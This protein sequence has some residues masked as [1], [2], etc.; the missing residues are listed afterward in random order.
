MNGSCSGRRISWS[1]CADVQPDL[2]LRHSWPKDLPS[3]DST[4]RHFFT[5]FYRIKDCLVLWGTFKSAFAFKDPA[6]ITRADYEPFFAMAKETNIPVNKVRLNIWHEE[7][8]CFYCSC[9]KRNHWV[10]RVEYIEECRK[11]WSVWV[12]SHMPYAISCWLKSVR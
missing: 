6:I 11:P 3:Q 1:S 8:K 5:I 9:R 7:W 10:E 12:V 4:Q 2:G